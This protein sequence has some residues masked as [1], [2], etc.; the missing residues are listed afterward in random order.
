MSLN[1]PPL[2]NRPRR[3]WR[4]LLRYSPMAILLVTTVAVSVMNHLR[5]VDFAESIRQLRSLEGTSSALMIAGVEFKEAALNLLIDDSSDPVVNERYL[6]AYT[7]LSSQMIV[8]DARTEHLEDAARFRKLRHLMEEIDHLH[9]RISQSTL[10]SEDRNSQ[11]RILGFLVQRWMLQVE[12]INAAIRLKTI[13]SDTALEALQRTSLM[14]F[15][16]VMMIALSLM[17]WLLNRWSRQQK[18]QLDREAFLHRMAEIDPLTGLLNRRGWERVSKAFDE[19]PFEVAR[20][21]TLIM[22]DLDH[23]KRFN[24]REGHAAGDHL[25]VR[26]AQL[27]Q[28]RSRPNDSLVRL[29]GEEFLMALPQCNAVDAEQLLNRLRNAQSLPVSFSAGV[30]EVK[31][32]ERI[33]DALHRADRALYRAKHLGR[34]RTCL[35]ESV[36]TGG[37]SGADMTNSAGIQ[38][39]MRVNGASGTDT[40]VNINGDSANPALNPV[41]GTDPSDG[42]QH[43]CPDRLGPA[44]SVTSFQR[45]GFF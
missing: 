29:G 41:I 25:L 26:F 22:L 3:E 20:G 13:Q 45:I 30:A 6:N 21:L 10:R 7:N 40:R 38:I 17:T 16:Y 37:P 35:A 24:D 28:G 4:T 11:I 31:V 39:G 34:S 44:P 8:A 42:G 33:A 43:I 9:Q 19:N 27:L 1:R 32:G 2:Q 36:E 18:A 15:A 12:A 14:V 5:S 23:F